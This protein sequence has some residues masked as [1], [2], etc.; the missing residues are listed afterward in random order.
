MNVQDITHV[1]WLIGFTI[2]IATLVWW[3]KDL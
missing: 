1:Y 3:N 2:V